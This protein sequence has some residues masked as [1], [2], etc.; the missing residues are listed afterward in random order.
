VVTGAFAASTTS[1]EILPSQAARR[2]HLSNRPPDNLV[3][4]H[5]QIMR[6]VLIRNA[7]ENVYV[8]SEHVNDFETQGVK[9]LASG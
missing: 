9:S 1:R 2:V 4:K 7:H 6:A 8:R 5:K 3:P